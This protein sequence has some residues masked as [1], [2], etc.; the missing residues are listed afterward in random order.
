VAIFT[1]DYQQRV[2]R[3]H[4]V[5][6]SFPDPKSS[7]QKQKRFD[8]E[9]TRLLITL[10]PIKDMKWDKSTT[11][12]LF[13]ALNASVRS[14]GFYERKM[15]QNSY[16]SEKFHAYQRQIHIFKRERQKT[17]RFCDQTVCYFEEEKRK[18]RNSLKMTNKE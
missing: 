11:F 9:L 3:L 6:Q 1:C 2:A 17:K 4:G 5:K 14:E 10:T 7:K 12:P 13:E 16:M 18:V 15:A 8:N